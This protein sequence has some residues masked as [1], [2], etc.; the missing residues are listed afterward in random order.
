MN[1]L[2]L[3]KNNTLK[4]YL[5]LSKLII[6][7]PFLI[8]LVIFRFFYKIKIIE[9]ET[10]AIGH[11]ALPIEIFLCEII[12]EIHDKNC[13]YIAFR[14]KFIANNFLYKKIKKKFSNFS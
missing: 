13:I 12:N 2:F 7:S 3:K 11:Y 14:N 9:I 10:R 4:N 1:F 5:Y 8:L 6:F